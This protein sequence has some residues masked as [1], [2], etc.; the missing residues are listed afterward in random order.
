MKLKQTTMLLTVLCLGAAL[1]G[2]CGKQTANIVA[3]D[4]LDYM[5][6][7][8]GDSAQILESGIVTI[9][10]ATTGQGRE[11]TLEV[12]ATDGLVTN[13]IVSLTGDVPQKGIEPFLFQSENL[14]PRS[15]RSKLLDDF[16][17][18][19]KS[20]Y[21]V[22]LVCEER[23][24]TGELTLLLN[25]DI[26]PLSLSFTIENKL[27]AA[28]VVFPDG[29]VSGE[30]ELRKLQ[31]SPMGFMLDCYEGNAEGGLPS[32]AFQLLFQDGHTEELHLEF[33]PSDETMGFGGGSAILGGAGELPLITDYYGTRD[34][35]GGFA[36]TGQ[37][38]RVLDVANIEK[39][40]VGE[41]E[42]SV[43]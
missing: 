14:R 15:I 37:F 32:T 17:G 22:E 5:K 31:V 43:E 10:S 12:V 25:E 20:V 42:Y 34:S 8:F 40:V 19:E 21:L 9:G 4:G 35:N 38:S 24:D 39:V 26:A 27:N 1:L 18:K 3:A 33:M 11:M 36:I 2:G 7:V 28:L 16:S 41:L 6:N 29:T 30:S 13:M 23:F